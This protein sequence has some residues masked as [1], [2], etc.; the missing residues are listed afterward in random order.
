MKTKTW[1]Y[2]ALAAALLGGAMVWAF[3]PRPVEVEVDTVKVGPFEASVEEDARTRLRDRYTVSAPVAGRLARIPLKEGD[4]VHIGDTL[5]ILS[6]G[7]P[8]MLDDRTRAEHRA[9]LDAAQA[10]VQRAKA[11]IALAIVL[12]RKADDEVLRSEQLG[13]QGFIPPA[14]L[15]TDRLAAQAAQEDRRTAE[16][17]LQVAQH[18]SE[19]ARAALMRVR[20]AETAS[21]S[22]PFIVRAPIEGRVL[23]VIQSSEAMVSLGAPLLEMGDTRSLEIVAECLTT[24]AIRL[25]PGG[26]VHIDRW[27]G[28]GALQ[29]RVRLVEPSAFTKVSALGVEEQRVRVLIDLSGPDVRWQGLGDGFRV[30]VRLVT[31]A[32]DKAIKVPLAAV[33]PLPGDQGDMA[34]FVKDGGRARLTRV[35]IGDGNGREALVKG[36]LPAGATVIVYPPA[37]VRDGVRVVARRV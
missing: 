18:E 25:R 8:A 29:G 26:L 12:T 37:T 4:H 3:A 17:D 19:Q 28:E 15:N 30:T 1:A 11:R 34:V 9:R 10:Q 6:P 35:K 16:L 14:K 23:K 24:D 5:A 22:R 27:G 13:M 7:L 20:E 2:G 31:V 33:F 32:L 36:G 21:G